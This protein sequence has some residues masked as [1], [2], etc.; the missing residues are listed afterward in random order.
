MSQSDKHTI[1]GSYKLRRWRPRLHWELVACATSGHELIGIDA[2]ALR[3]EDRIFAREDADGVRWF[4][5]VRC[6]SWVPLAAP[7]Q[8]ASEFP[9]PRDAVELPLRGKALRDKYVLRLIAIDR[10]FHTLVL[11]IVAA[12]IFLFAANEQ[13]LRDPVFRVLENVQAALGGPGKDP[14]HGVAH[15]VRHLFALKKATLQEV[16]ALLTA[17]A[18]LEL[19]EAVG[20]WMA[21]RWAEYLTFI[22][23]T[24]LLP[25]EIHELTR[26]V[27]FFKVSALVINLAVVIYLLWA[28]RLFGLRGGGKAEAAERERDLGWPALE[29]TAPGATAAEAT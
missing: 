10:I 9:P 14:Q 8:P 28:K 7:D 5:C 17:Y 18:A 11:G 22:A 24:V 26:R 20:L 27:T 4:R 15:E 1:P 25:L 16:A 2:R 3:E 21:K 23:T 13:S 12:A 29:R 19:V 6:D